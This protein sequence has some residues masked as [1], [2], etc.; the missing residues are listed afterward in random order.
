MKNKEQKISIS[1]IYLN[2]ESKW[3]SIRK[4]SEILELKSIHSRCKSIKLIHKSKK[5]P[6]KITLLKECVI[7]DNSKS[8][9]S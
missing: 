9:L 4:L 5:L 2:L 8:T 1:T 7:T 6:D 3:I